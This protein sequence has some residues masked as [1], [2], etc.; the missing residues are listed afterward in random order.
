M[1]SANVESAVSSLCVLSSTFATR[2]IGLSVLAPLPHRMFRK[3]ETFCL[4]FHAFLLFV[5]GPAVA[6]SGANSTG[7]EVAAALPIRLL[8]RHIYR[9]TGDFGHHL[10]VVCLPPPIPIPWPSLVPD[11]YVLPRDSYGLGSGVIISIVSSR[12]PRR[13]QRRSTVSTLKART[14]L[15]PRTIMTCI[16][17]MRSSTKPSASCHLLRRTLCARFVMTPQPSCSAQW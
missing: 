9:G 10:S 14:Y 3:L 5:P 12:T 15:T 16:T 11:V 4:S 6:A 8:L 13:M 17:S 2:R 1:L 7:I